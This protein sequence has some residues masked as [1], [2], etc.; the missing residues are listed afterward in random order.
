MDRFRAFINTVF[1]GGFVV[2][3][4][5]AILGLV[6]GV[7]VKFVTGLIEP[8]TQLLEDHFGIAGVSADFVV[9]G[10]ILLLCFLVGLLVQTRFGKAIHKYIEQKYLEATPGYKMIKETTEQL[11]SGKK[12]PLSKVALVAPFGNET[13][14]TAFIT[15]EHTDGSFT[16][17]IPMSPPTSGFV[18]HLKASQVHPVEVTTEEAMKTLLSLG[19]GSAKLMEKYRDNI[20]PARKDQ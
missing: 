12:S 2:V 4:P 6:F 18:F 15:N 14:V 19:A 10:L 17:F 13:L 20:K 8:L 16:V 3:L 5:I 1:I 11:M 7:L 9:I